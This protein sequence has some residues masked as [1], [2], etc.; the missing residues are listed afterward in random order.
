MSGAE[1]RGKSGVWEYEPFASNLI[2]IHYKGNYITMTGSAVTTEIPIH[3]PHRIVKIEMNHTDS[4]DDASTDAWDYKLRR[5]KGKLA[6]IGNMQS[7]ILTVTNSAASEILETFGENYE[8]RAST[9]D[10]VMDTTNTDRV[11]VEL[12]VQRL[13]NPKQVYR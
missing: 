7:T 8:Y 10:L 2:R 11:Y 5:T 9:W 12:T 6:G 13:S 4:S 1:P 3:W